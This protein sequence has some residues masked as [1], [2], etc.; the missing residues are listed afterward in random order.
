MAE[1]KS[2]P[3]EGTE[4]TT[5]Q[6]ARLPISVLAADPKNPRVMSDEERHGL[7][8]SLETF[9][10]LDLVFNETSGEM[11]SGHQRIA[12]L[13]AAGATDVVRIDQDWGHIIHPKTGE[14][15]M[16]RFVR[17]GATMQSLANLAANN[18]AL[19]GEFT[20]DAVG[21]LSAL[22]DH[23]K[24]EALRLDELQRSLDDEIDDAEKKERERAGLEDFEIPPPPKKAWILIATSSDRIPEIEDAV[25]KFEDADTRVEVSCGKAS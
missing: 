5:Q 12:N 7:A 1:K 15:F 6:P 8:V 2:L 11:V 24:F 4:A 16:I 19:Q 3:R 23:E 18:P 10:P 21:Q 22:E 17:W 13:K 20:P 9:G 14:K 25:R